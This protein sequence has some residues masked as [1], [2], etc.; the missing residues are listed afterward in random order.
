MTARL[1]RLFAVALV[2]AFVVLTASL[3]EAVVVFLSGP[4]ILQEY[5][6]CGWAYG[7]FQVSFDPGDDTTRRYQFF[8][9]ADFT[10]PLSA[11]YVFSNQL[12]YSPIWWGFSLDYTPPADNTVT[13]RLYVGSTMA[14]IT[15][16]CTTGQG[17]QPP[18][19]APE[20]FT[21][22]NLF[23]TNPAPVAG[24]IRIYSYFGEVFQPEGRQ[25]G[26]IAV[27]QGQ[28][29]NNEPLNAYCNAH[30]RAWFFPTEEAIEAAGLEEYYFMPSQYGDP[31][32]GGG[33]YG[34]STGGDPSYHTSFPEIVAPGVSGAAPELTEE[35]KAAGLPYSPGGGISPFGD[36]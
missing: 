28:Q 19:P 4:T 35:D 25:I 27:A 34:T 32:A 6:S 9:N 10:G 31:T 18:V 2:F 29:I 7:E 14:H 20:C 13:L 23:T 26:A 30:V 15:Y 5:S 16:D 1:R 24:T 8:D 11:E 17:V 33:D 3:A 12:P 22:F 36:S 21:S